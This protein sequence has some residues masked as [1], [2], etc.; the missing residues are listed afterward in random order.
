ML[1][2]VAFDMVV[3]LRFLFFNLNKYCTEGDGILSI[4]GKQ[5][6]HCMLLHVTTKVENTLSV[7]VCVS[8]LLS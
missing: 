4:A 8:K 3:F 5:Y 2:A 6:F 1:V 7:C